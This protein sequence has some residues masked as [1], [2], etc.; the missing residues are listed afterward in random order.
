MISSDAV[1]IGWG[2][3]TDSVEDPIEKANKIIV[4]EECKLTAEKLKR[5]DI[6]KEGSYYL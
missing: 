3:K 1:I 5:V 4:E 6:H 2:A